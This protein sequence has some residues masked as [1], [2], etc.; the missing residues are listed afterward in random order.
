MTKKLDLKDKPRECLRA[1]FVRGNGATCTNLTA[2]CAPCDGHVL[3]YEAMFL[4]MPKATELD[5]ES[6]DDGT[7]GWCMRLAVDWPDDD[8]QV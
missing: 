8:E 6:Y 5:Y 7:G 3:D 4:S 2:A 1:R